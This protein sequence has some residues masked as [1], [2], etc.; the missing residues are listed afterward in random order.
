MTH[1][2]FVS[3]LHDSQQQYSMIGTSVPDLSE[4]KK[5]GGKMITFH[6]MAD[7]IIPFKGS[8]VYY[9]KVSEVVDDQDFYRYFPVPGLGHCMGGY[10]Q[11]A[12]LFA[13]LQAW[14]ENGTAPENP[15]VSFSDLDGIIQNRTICPWS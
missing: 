15:P 11:P 2:Q 8:G 6:R 10:Q 4:F 3:L 12:S 9:Q 13:Q 7:N 14:V 1:E 5:T